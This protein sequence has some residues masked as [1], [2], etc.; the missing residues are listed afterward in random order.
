MVERMGVGDCMGSVFFFFFEEGSCIFKEPFLQTLTLGE[1]CHTM[2]RKWRIKQKFL[3][4]TH[5][6]TG[7]EC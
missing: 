3:H 5:L 7:N 2:E 6:R 4:V 1:N